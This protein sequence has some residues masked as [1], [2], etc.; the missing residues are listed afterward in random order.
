MADA[1]DRE[2]YTTHELARRWKLD[3]RTLQRW[4]NSG[5]GPRFRRLE[6]R[7]RY[8]ASDIL[9]FE[10]DAIENRDPVFPN[11]DDEVCT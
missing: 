11:S 7:V 6:G 5:K 2:F 4:R 8:A 10:A 9:E 1:D 3:R